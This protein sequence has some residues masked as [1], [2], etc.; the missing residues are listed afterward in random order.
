MI[1]LGIETSCDETAAAVVEDG[2]RLLGEVLSSQIPI[3]AR[4]GGVVP[5]AASRQHM[6]RIW[7][8]V[9]EAMQKA[10]ITNDRLDAVAVTQGPGLVGA[11]LV[12]MSFGKAMAFGLG[13]PVIAVNHLEGHLMSWILAE[14]QP[15]LPHVALVASG[16]HTELYLVET[17]GN[18]RVLGRT[19]DD[20][21][22]EAFDKGAKMLGLEYPGGPAIDRLARKGDRARVSFPRPMRDQPG[23][24]F[25]FSGL[26]TA[27]KR[28]L[29]SPGN[30]QPIAP[31]DLAASYQEAIV[32]VLV[33]K[34]IK[35]AREFNVDAVVVTGGVAANTC[36]RE[37][38]VDRCGKA[39]IRPFLPPTARCTDN[40]GMIAAAAYY[41]WRSG[42]RDARDVNAIPTLRPAAAS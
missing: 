42:K 38:L 35:A 13:L 37:R 17:L 10:G 39:G 29:S 31:E 20:A 3:H 7:P 4:F 23:Y 41:R 16:G 1:I 14:D 21:A 22:G 2:R 26:K 33:E 28:V 34:T 25:S 36:L 19:R 15:R 27:L 40:A 11:L 12:G 8:V 6:E 30:G 9:E 5:E 18:H 32:D 24:D